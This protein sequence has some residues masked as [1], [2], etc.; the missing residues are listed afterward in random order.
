MIGQLNIV[1]KDSSQNKVVF[2][3]S[4]EGKK[5]VREVITTHG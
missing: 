4:Q 5:G 2:L 3:L 1:W